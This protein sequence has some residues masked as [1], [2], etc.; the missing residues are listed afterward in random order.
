MQTS[1][2]QWVGAHCTV[3]TAAGLPESKQSHRTEGRHHLGHMGAQV[4]GRYAER[5]LLE[6]TAALPWELWYS[7]HLRRAPVSTL[8]GTGELRQ[9]GCVHME[10]GCHCWDKIGAALVC[11]RLVSWSL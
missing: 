10:L 1:F 5:V 11:P 3:E 9:V 2:D 6:V 8:W 4:V 7:V